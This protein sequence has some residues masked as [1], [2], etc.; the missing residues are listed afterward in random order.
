MIHSVTTKI[1]ESLKTKDYS[2]V[3]N[4]PE[5]GLSGK[6]FEERSKPHLTT[7]SNAT[8]PLA[9]MVLDPE[10]FPSRSMAMRAIRYV[11]CDDT[12]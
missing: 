5:T 9:M 3:W 10:M 4:V 8:L 1:E 11:S 12:S 6:V 7:S 2:N